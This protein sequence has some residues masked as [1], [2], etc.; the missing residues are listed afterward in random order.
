MIIP[1]IIYQTT[2][3]PNGA[4]IEIQ[5]IDDVIL[6]TEKRMNNKNINKALKENYNNPISFI[7]SFSMVNKSRYIIQWNAKRTFERH[8]L[9]WHSDF[10]PI[11]IRRDIKL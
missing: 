11:T 2:E 10:Y 6:K 4:T 7:Y 3:K 8:W 5:H 9:S 1:F